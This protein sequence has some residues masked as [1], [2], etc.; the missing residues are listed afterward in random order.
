[1][2]VQ[3]PASLV[4]LESNGGW[5]EVEEGSQGIGIFKSSPGDSEEQPEL[6]TTGSGWVEGKIYLMIN[7]WVKWK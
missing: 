6:R 5:G 3:V 4:K 2:S 7:E 1:M